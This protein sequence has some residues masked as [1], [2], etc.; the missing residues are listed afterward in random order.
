MS[1]IKTIRKVVE[2]QDKFLIAKQKEHVRRVEKSVA[3][4]QKKI[5]N[6]MARLSTTD[7]GELRGLR[8]NLK[9]SQ[10]VHARIIS[11]YESE[12]NSRTKR[13]IEEFDEITDL[14]RKGYKDLGASVRFT[15][16]DRTAMKVLQDGMYRDYIA[17]SDTSRQKVIQAMYDHILGAGETANL[18]YQ[19]ESALMGSDV[20][21]G[22]GRTLASL[23]RLY[24]RDMVMNFHQEVQLYKAEEAGLDQFL[25]IGDIIETTRDFCRRRVGKVYTKQQIESWTFKWAGKS[26]PALTNRGGYNCRHHWQPVRE[27]WLEGKKKLDVADWNLEQIKRG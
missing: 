15:S 16:V 6:S 3:A 2:E 10:R 20:A 1:D 26:G 27:E 22:T 4:L 18:V 12:F 13:M 24:A 19:I 25:Y 7:D 23:S 17:I 9:Q 14:V 21:V 5:I 8:V 11:L